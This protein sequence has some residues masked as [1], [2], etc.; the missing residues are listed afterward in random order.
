VQEQLNNIVKHANASEVYINIINDE[1]HYLLEIKDN[2]NGFD[3]E[4]VRKG[5]GLTN[6]RN[7]AELFGGKVSVLAAPGKG[8]MLKVILPHAVGQQEP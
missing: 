8:C 4:K 3:L 1:S 5:L 6:I 7:R 2:G